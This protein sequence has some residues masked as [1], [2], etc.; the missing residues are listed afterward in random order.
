LAATPPAITVEYARQIDQTAGSAVPGRTEHNMVYRVRYRDLWT[1]IEQIA[2]K[3]QVYGGPTGSLLMQVPWQC[4][5]RKG[6]WAERVSWKGVALPPYGERTAG[7]EEYYWADVTINFA[8]PQFPYNDETWVTTRISGADEYITLPNRVFKFHDGYKTGQDYGLHVPQI[9]VV[10]TRY[11]VPLLDR[12]A[13]AIFANTGCVNADPVDWL[14]PGVTCDVGTVMFPA[15][16]SD[17]TAQV[18]GSVDNTISL[19][20][21]WRRISWQFALHPDGVTG[22]AEIVDGNG[23]PPYPWTDTMQDLVKL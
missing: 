19:V 18:S 16:S 22:F 20:F 11:R 2:G 9:E 10:K 6:L 21:R 8:T 4:P 5:E 15:P 3:A 12:I 7:K 17:I 14:V 13:P 23:E 1:F